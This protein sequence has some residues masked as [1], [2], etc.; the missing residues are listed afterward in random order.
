MSRGSHGFTRATGN[1]FSGGETNLSPLVC[2]GFVFHQN[3]DRSTQLLTRSTWSLPQAN[4]PHMS[5]HLPTPICGETVAGEI[6]DGVSSPPTTPPH[7]LEHNPHYLDWRLVALSTTGSV[8]THLSFI[9]FW[10]RCH[11]DYLRSTAIR[12][13]NCAGRADAEQ[14]TERDKKKNRELGREREIQ[15]AEIYSICAG[16]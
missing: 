10:L 2:A 4:F 5:K 7:L 6:A 16:D 14:G 1:P 9:P 11:S 12:G 8:S 13:S 3:L 15:A